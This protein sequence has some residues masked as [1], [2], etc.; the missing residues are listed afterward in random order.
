MM[1]GMGRYGVQTAVEEGEE[2]K[3]RRQVRRQEAERGDG[4]L[5]Q[6]RKRLTKRVINE[7]CE[8]SRTRCKL[9]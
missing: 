7:V 6:W 4:Q 8:A 3:E 5:V 1:I 9:H 2:D